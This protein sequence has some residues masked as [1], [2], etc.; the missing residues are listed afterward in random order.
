[1]R[2]TNLA[3]GARPPRTRTTICCVA[4]PSAIRLRPR[5]GPRPSGPRPGR[6]RDTGPTCG[7]KFAAAYEAL[8]ELAR[9]LETE[10]TDFRASRS[11]SNVRFLP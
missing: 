5:S 8:S 4:D 3:E 9:R 10:H 11:L 7:A 6:V 2:V 1:M